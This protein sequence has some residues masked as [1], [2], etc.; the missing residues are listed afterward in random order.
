MRYI[1]IGFGNIGQKRKAFLGEKCVAIV[2]PVHPE[3]T[4][5]SFKDVPLSDYDAA[6]LATPNSVKIE[7]LEYLLNNKKHVLIEKPM[8]FSDYHVSTKLDN[9]SKTNKAI[10]YTSYNHTFEPLILKLKSYLKS[11][12]LG[13]IYFAQF[14]YGNGTVNNIKETWR[15]EG[16]GVLEDLGCH[17]I[18]L[19]RFLFQCDIEYKAIALHNYEAT[20]ID[21]CS[22]S[23]TDNNLI[24]Q[25]SYLM[26]KN[27]FTIDVFGHDGSIHLNG[28]NKWGGASLLLRERIFPCGIP[29]EKK[30]TSSGTDNTW[31]ADINHFEN[32]VARKENSFENDIMITNA[33]NNIY[34]N[35]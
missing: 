8:L 3:A 28:L 20:G 15:D 4:F 22:F 33:I 17:L 25:C 7:A 29:I 6:I 9:I 13:K 18:D 19:A 1:I 26:W 30:E 23:S 5:C 10:W 21:H 27:T 31:E 11:N 16:L 35:K 34:Q 24:F 2:D 12:L 32:M 14:T